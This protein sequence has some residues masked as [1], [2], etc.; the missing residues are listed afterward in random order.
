MPESPP[1]IGAAEV[2]LLPRFW[3]HTSL[4]RVVTSLFI[5]GPRMM[6]RSEVFEYVGKKY[7]RDKVARLGTVNMYQ[8]R[9]AL[10]ETAGAMAL[11]PWLLDPVAD[12]TIDAQ[13]P[14]VFCAI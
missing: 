4:E 13:R 2:E 8:P 9:S 12:G 14:F 6:G 11:A 10:K 1:L 5:A 7:G 3:L